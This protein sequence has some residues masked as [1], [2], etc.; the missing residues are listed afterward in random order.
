[1][2]LSSTKLQNIAPCLFPQAPGVGV[3]MIPCCG[4]EQLGAGDGGQQRPLLLPHQAG[5]GGVA[6]VPRDADLELR[7][8]HLYYVHEDSD[9]CEVR[10]SREK[11]VHGVGSWSALHEREFLSFVE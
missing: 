6:G 3:C 7:R 10:I 2:R 8:G 9:K 1:M 11:P 5:D 4:H